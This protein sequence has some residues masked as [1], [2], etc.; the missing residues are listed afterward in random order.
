MNDIEKREI[1]NAPI[2]AIGRVLK[3]IPMVFIGSSVVNI[4]KDM[5]NKEPIK[6]SNIAVG[7]TGLVIAYFI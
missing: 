3:I 5:R 7:L 2:D 1:I 6:K 4:I